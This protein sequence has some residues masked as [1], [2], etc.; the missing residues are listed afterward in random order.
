MNDIFINKVLPE[1]AIKECLST[2]LGIG[3]DEIYFVYDWEL[4]FEKDY[5]LLCELRTLNGSYPTYLSLYRETDFIKDGE[6][7]LFCEDFCELMDCFIILS[8][9]EIN[10]YSWILIDNKRKHFHVY[11]DPNKL[12]DDEENPQFEIT[13]MG[14][15]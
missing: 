10:P 8:D 14:Q 6:F 12:D 2:L 15:L 7:K 11:L 3:T 5:K 4:P 9:D 13:H 1:V